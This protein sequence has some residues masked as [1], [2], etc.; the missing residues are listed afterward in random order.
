MVKA[1]NEEGKRVFCYERLKPERN[2][3][4]Y[5]DDEDDESV[6]AAEWWFWPVDGRG[7]VG[8]GVV[9]RVKGEKKV[10]EKKTEEIKEEK[11]AET[12]EVKTVADK[13][14][15]TKT[16]DNQVTAAP[17]SKSWSLLKFS[18]SV[19]KAAEKSWENV[20]QKQPKQKGKQD[21]KPA[22]DAQDDKKDKQQQDDKK[23][24]KKK[25]T[26]DDGKQKQKQKPENDN[27]KSLTKTT[28]DQKGWSFAVSWSVFEF[29][30]P[31]RGQQAGEGK[32]V[33]GGRTP[34]WKRS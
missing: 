31:P 4:V 14:A 21:A 24:D 5:L 16:E 12:K 19:D 20:Q 30:R 6:K 3:N 27:G 8:E 10:E 28:T 25:G 23:D 18:L 9:E 22:P 2:I 13:K 26:K 11:K 32:Q 33:S 29:A 15:Q 34:W 17:P 7:I 1:H